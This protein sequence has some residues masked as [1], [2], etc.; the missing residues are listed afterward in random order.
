[1]FIVLNLFVQYLLPADLT[2][3]AQNSGFDGS[4]PGVVIRKL[5]KDQSKIPQMGLTGN[6]QTNK[7]SLITKIFLLSPSS[8]YIYIYIYITNNLCLFFFFCCFC[9]DLLIF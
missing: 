3:R 2:K 9:S 5:S 6:Q 4:Y 7:K 1:M 8:T